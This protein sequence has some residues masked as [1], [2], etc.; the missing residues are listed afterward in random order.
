[1]AVR[2]LLG[3]SCL[4]VLSA[5][6]PQGLTP[7]L[8][9]KEAAVAGSVSLWSDATVPTAFASLDTGAIELGLKFKSS[10]AGSVAGVRFYKAS[11]NTGTHVGRLWTTSGSLLASAT[12]TSET[13]TGWQTATFASP[14]ALQPGTVYVVS[15]FA[16]NGRY[17]GEA[18]YFASSG[19]TA[20]PLYALRD[21]ESGGNGLYL[22]S[23]TGGFP[24]ATNES[25]NYSVDVVFVPKTGTGLTGQYFD[26]EDF[27]NLKVT[28]VDPQVSFDWMGGSPA[29]G[30]ASNTF[31]ARWTGQVQAPIAGTYTFTT[32]SDDG[33]RLWVNGQKLIDNW[34][35]HSLTTN[36]GQIALS[37]GQR[38][39]LKL[40][41][42]ERNGNANIN[43]SWAIPGD[44]VKTI[45][46]TYLFPTSSA[47]TCTPNCS[48]KQCG[49]D[50]CGGTCG[51]CA[52]GQSCGAAGLC[53]SSC[54]PSCSGKQCGSDGC[55]GTCGS[56][57]S[58]Q[59]CSAA[60][61]CASSCTR[62]CS[63]KQCGS[64]GC[65]GTCGSCASGQTCSAAG[66][67]T[68]TC[69]PSCS[70]K[71]C[72]SDGCGGS[73]GSCASGQ[74][75]SAAGTC[76][77]TCTR[78]CSGKQCGSDGC[79]GTCGTCA[80]GQTCSAAG[81]CAATCTPSC[82]GKQ[83]GSDGC[84]GTCGSCASGQ[85]CSAAGTCTT[86]TT[87]NPT[88]S[89]S[90]TL[91]T[92]L[93]GDA[94]STAQQRVSQGL[95]TGATFHPPLTG[96][97]QS[98]LSSTSAP[99]AYFAIPAESNVASCYPSATDS[100]AGSLLTSWTNQIGPDVWRLGMPE[101]DQGGGCWANGRPTLSGLNDAQAYAAWTG[102]YLDTKQLRPYLS[103]S[104]QQRGYKWMTV[105]SFA[106]SAQYAF[107]MG[108]DLVLVERNEDEMSG[109]T[110]GLAMVRGAA[111]Q[112]GNRDWGIDFSTWRY[113][114][115][116]PT[117]YSAGRLVTGWST[118]TFKRNMFIAYMGGS[119][120]IHNEAADYTS[121]AASGASLNPLG[122]TV[123]QF[124]D[125]AVKR[126]PN[127][128]TPYVPMAFL[129]EHNSGFEPKFGEWMQGNS[130]WYWKNG[131]TAG[132]TLFA[133]LLSFAFP[134]YN[135]WGTLPSG[136]PKVLNSDGS[137]NTSSTF[138][139]YK[140]ALANGT[141]PRPW[142]PFGN[143]RFG[144]TI[145]MI[146]NQASL[147]AL[148]RYKVVVLATGAAMSDAMVGTLTQYVQQ[149]GTVVLT[150]K[151]LPS[152]A[153]AQTLTGLSF[154][155]GR[156]SAASETWVADGSSITE[157]SYNYA[158][159]SPT[160]ASI[161]ASTS[162]NPIVARNTLGSGAVWTITADF[163][164]D[165]GNSAILN[166]AQKVLSNLQTQLSLVQVQGPQLE[167]LVSTDGGKV[168][169]TLVNTS[170]SGAAWSGTLSFNLPASSYSVKEW[171]GDT[172]VSSSVQSGKVVV[173]ASVPGYDVRVYALEAN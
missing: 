9:G 74:V 97:E 140:Q 128:G 60:G 113:W 123:Q 61:T 35:V 131:Y 41:Y 1:M 107:D 85:T 25:N 2:K 104:A 159:A 156:T 39:D 135:T 56:C 136:A 86:T 163:M 158:I 23:A 37:A 98:F 52:S 162:G 81:T 108:S 147:A 5:C 84:G 121:G 172:A 32:T 4:V 19:R 78:S 144:E 130:K 15:Y 43:L 55:G 14:V 13:A 106:F 170:L 115:D 146:T 152:T 169:V 58:G 129:Q 42:F 87:P 120:V 82:S 16:P 3:L 150:A 132:D 112:H 142:E 126:H 17:A 31:S 167:Y 67:C 118:S 103:Q 21:G 109:I 66:L 164:S 89:P 133:N 46:S 79:G 27:T 57:A 92:E 53:T 124:H 47:G 102:F 143:S 99:F 80:S 72:G 26:N 59:T 157:K 68:S 62:S 160:T 30:I 91:M 63:G 88:G 110:P 45:P 44:T 75:C 6:G 134:G 94:G 165:A 10:V 161:V 119:N 117:A 40:E 8:G 151:Q 69:T 51:S 11:G 64:D 50:G 155:G 73:C 38:C 22:R 122:Q 49:S 141:D 77:A 148:Q 28:R 29:S 173:N 149:G 153:A 95:A 138:A 137:I 127:R 20:G 7:D 71:Q 33:V 24:T 70:G 96:S 18:G 36:S 171:T 83:C 166:V 93:Y 54:T 139:A 101:F 154:T 125:F 48:G 76:A 111:R 114:N 65:G 100:G 168:I 90:F 105:C 116:G 12:F 145:D 34:T